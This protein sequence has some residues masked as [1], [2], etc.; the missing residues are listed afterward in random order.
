MRAVIISGK[1][2]ILER[3][4]FNIVFCMYYNLISHI[5]ALGNV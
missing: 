5:I 1:Y 4:I 2:Q 3:D